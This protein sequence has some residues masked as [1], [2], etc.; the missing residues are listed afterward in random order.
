MVVSYH[1]SS[2]LIGNFD[3][4]RLITVVSPSEIKRHEYV[5]L[6]EAQGAPG[7]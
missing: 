1:Q 3:D 5:L 4:K 6:R 2:S 7:K